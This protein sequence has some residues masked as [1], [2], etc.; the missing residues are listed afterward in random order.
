[1]PHIHFID[2]MKAW[3]MLLIVVGHVIGDPYAVFNLSSQPIYTK[4]IG[5]AIFIFVMGWSLANETRAPFRVFYNRLFAMYFYGIACALILSAYFWF[6][7]GDLAESNY[8][9]FVAGANVL[10]NYFPANTTTWYIGTYFHLVVLWLFFLR[11]RHITMRHLGVAFLV[12][13]AC[14]TILLWQHVDFIAYMTLPNWLMVFVLGMYFVGRRD[15]D[16]SDRRLKRRNL[17]L[18]ITLWIGLWVL[19]AQAFG[20]LS[21]GVEFPF[22]YLSLELQHQT[23]PFLQV[24]SKLCLSLLVSLTYVV[25]TLLFFEIARRLPSLSIVRFFARNTLII[26]LFHMAIIFEV[27]KSYYA[28]VD[29]DWLNRPSLIA[30]VYIGLALF[31][32]GVQKV[33][34][35]RTLREALW[36]FSAK[37]LAIVLPSRAFQ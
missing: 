26:F 12:E 1:M 17:L 5:V 21:F 37:V 24:L 19:Y 7:I 4:Q 28:M 32:E 36:P 20:W 10:L 30:L 2:W 8:L 11:N 16:S 3:G 6:K 9:P 35:L 14:R 29:I 23:T 31:S 13:T 18:W 33:V 27:H 22:R 15:A 34:P 25:N